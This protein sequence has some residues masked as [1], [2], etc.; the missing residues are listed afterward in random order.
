MRRRRRRRSMKKAEMK[1]VRKSEKL[2]F[3]RRP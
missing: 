1:R 2:V 3:C